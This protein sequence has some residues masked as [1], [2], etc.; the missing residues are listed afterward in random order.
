MTEETG[1][2][3]NI[4][5]IGLAVNAIDM[6][7]KAGA[8]EGANMEIIGAARNRLHAAVQ[9]AQEAQ[10]AQAPPPNSGIQ[11]NVGVVDEAEVVIEE[12]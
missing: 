8:F 1:Q 9:A 7:S 2:Q 6:A 10:A 4:G 5:D 11:D 3:I 12:E